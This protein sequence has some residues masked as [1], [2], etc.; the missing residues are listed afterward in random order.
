VTSSKQSVPYDKFLVLQL[1]HETCHLILQNLELTQCRRLH[2]SVQVFDT[3]W[4]RQGNELALSYVNVKVGGRR[5]T[6]GQLAIAPS[7]L[8][9][10]RHQ[11]A[12]F[13]RLKR[14][15]VL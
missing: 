10:R 14:R 15:T 4:I 12:F 2:V 11:G 5:S 3:I 6:I 8:G 7:L 13:R 9:D 1:L